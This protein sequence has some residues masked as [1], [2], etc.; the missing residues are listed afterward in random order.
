MRAALAEKALFGGKFILLSGV[1]LPN[2]FHFVVVPSVEYLRAGA[3][4]PTVYRISALP[5]SFEKQCTER[6]KK[7]NIP[8]NSFAIRFFGWEN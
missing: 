8:E 3:R 1:F 6:K 5:F 2:F 4:V 7:V